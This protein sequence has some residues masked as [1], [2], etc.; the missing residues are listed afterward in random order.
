MKYFA[1]TFDAS[2]CLNF[3]VLTR[4][5]AVLPGFREKNGERLN[6]RSPKV[7][8]RED[9]KYRYDHTKLFFLCNGKDE[10]IRS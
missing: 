9:Y 6:K 7:L 8:P 1:S 2:G 4:L 5:C 10:K 3:V